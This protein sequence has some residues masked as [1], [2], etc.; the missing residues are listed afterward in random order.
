MFKNELLNLIESLNSNPISRIS[1]NGHQ[2]ELVKNKN[3]LKN[4]FRI[5]LNHSN[6]SKVNISLYFHSFY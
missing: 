1:L 3:N 5:M 6:Q 2:E 4:C